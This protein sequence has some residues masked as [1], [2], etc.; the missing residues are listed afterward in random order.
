[1]VA[2]GFVG[3][4]DDLGCEATG[5]IKDIGPGLHHEDFKRGDRVCI[6]GSS[7]L[8]TSVIT[9]SSRC[10]KLPAE[11]SLEDAA[12]VPC[13]YATVVHSLLILGRLERGQSVLIHSACGGVGLAAI[14]I[15]QMVGAEVSR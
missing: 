13:V 2:M 7:L 4:K 10:F 1:M 6:L 14:Q 11:I 12:T 3:Q 9:Q 5:L 15:C 8:R